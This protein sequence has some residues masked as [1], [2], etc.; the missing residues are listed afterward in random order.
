MSKGDSTSDHLSRSGVHIRIL[1]RYCGDPA[2]DGEDEV[3]SESTALVVVATPDI[4]ADYARDLFAS[5]D[6]FFHPTA[7]VDH[8]LL[9]GPEGWP[10]ATMLRWHVL[11]A[12]L[13]ATDYVWLSDAD[14]RFEAPCG[15]EILPFPDGIVAVKHPGYIGKPNHELPFERR[16]ESKAYVG[17]SDGDIYYA[18]G[19]IGGSLGAMKTFCQRVVGIIDADKANGVTAIWHDESVANR[20]I[21]SDGVSKSLDPRYCAPDDASWYQTFWDRDYR[22]NAV[23]VALDKPKSVRGER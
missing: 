9:Y 11:L 19:F 3:V 23:L 12:N 14:M 4:Y 2:L 7:E 17:L 1:L 22:A 15:P 10:D 20:V 18:G 5:A 6:T 21:A 8:V 16:L 13:P